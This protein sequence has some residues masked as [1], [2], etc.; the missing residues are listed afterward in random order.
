[1]INQIEIESFNENIR[2]QRILGKITGKKNGPTVVAFGGIHGNERAG[3]NALLRVFKKISDDKIPMLGNFYGI[4][5][6]LN[7]ISKNV[8]FDKVDLNRI[9]T[10]EAILNLHLADE[11]DYENEEIR[12]QKEV[13]QIIK[14]IIDS[15]KGPFYFLDLHTTS[16]DTQ[17]FINISDS[18]NNRKYSAN[19]SIPTILGIEEFLKGPLLTYMNDFGHISLGFEAGQHD[20]EESV[21][22]CISFLW[23][24]LV[25]ANCVRKNDIDK[26]SFY[27]HSLATFKETQVFYQI[28]YKYTIKPTENF[29]MVKGYENFQEIKQEELLA[30]SNNSEV[31][32]NIDGKIFMP[33]YQQKGDDG[34][35]IISELSK[36]WLNASI[37]LRKLHL[38]NFLKLLPGVSSNK[39]HPYTL[40]VNPKTAKFLA[41][42]IFHLFGYRKKVLKDNKYHFIKRDRKVSTFL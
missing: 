22:N 32:A 3:I 24:A 41:T 36:F 40:I 17:P 1:M 34:Y 14:N 5:G 23:L 2:I 13:Y 35:F 16:A 28:D 12:E 18:L 10:D 27:K 29:K 31:K 9:W 33:L 37:V 19:F 11:N 21:D 26:Y 25:A 6:N 8:R 39:R 42:D 30:Y 4:A 15:E 7:A 20:K 38:H